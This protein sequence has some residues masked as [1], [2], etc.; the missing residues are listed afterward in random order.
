MLEGKAEQCKRTTKM[1]ARKRRDQ[2]TIYLV[3]L[4]WQTVVLTY[5]VNMLV[6]TVHLLCIS[7]NS[8]SY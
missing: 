2:R 8:S 7:E 3:V 1:K 5:L 6:S 4:F